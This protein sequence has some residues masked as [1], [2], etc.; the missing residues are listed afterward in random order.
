MA[1]PGWYA[2]PNDPTRGRYW[3]GANWTEVRDGIGTPLPAFPDPEV[4]TDTAP[5][6]AVIG[7]DPGAL[8]PTEAVPVATGAVVDGEAYEEQYEEPDT[9]PNAAKWAVI[10]LLIVAAIVAGV[11]IW[12]AVDDSDPEPPYACAD[13]ISVTDWNDSTFVLNGG[14]AQSWPAGTDPGS[15]DA[16]Q[17]VCDTAVAFRD[18][19]QGSERA[20]A[21]TTAPPTTSRP[22]TTSPTSAPERPA[23]TAPPAPDAVPVGTAVRLGNGLGLTVDRFVGD[24]SGSLT[25][26]FG[27][28]PQPGNG[29]RWAV[30][31]LRL[32]NPTDS[33][34]APGPMGLQLVSA[35]GT[36]GAAPDT[37][38]Q[39]DNPLDM[40]TPVPASG[41]VTGDVVFQVPTDEAS[42][43][44][45]VDG[46]D[47]R[48]LMALT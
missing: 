23:S 45:Q 22:A 24:G 42:P 26:D 16:L 41:S 1:E 5:T 44:L 18:A 30:V 27:Q 46:G 6:M 38:A 9:R 11:L 34:V 39:T 29:R 35:E 14:P 10:G 28:A 43:L 19:T 36:G 33:P 3:D 4:V 47:G 13:D 17:Q 15:K 37:S 31:T 20:D 8:P 32:T 48:V 40:A 2:H 12:L 21:T 7:H 25:S